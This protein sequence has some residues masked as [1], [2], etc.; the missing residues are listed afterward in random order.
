MYPI[1]FHWKTITIYSYGFFIALAMLVNFFLVNR[2][3]R[4]LGFSVQEANDLLFILFVFGIVGARLFYVAQHMDDYRSDGWQALN[5]HEGG[6]VW[7]GGFTVSV[8]AGVI[9]AR[10][11]GWPILKWCDFFTPH[12]ALGHA[13]GRLGCFFNGCCYGRVSHSMLGVVFDGDLN[14]RLP[15]QLYESL[16]LF[17]LAWGLFQAAPR[18]KPSGKLFCIYLLIYALGRF[19]L[20]FLRGDQLLYAGWTVPQWTSVLLAVVAIFS[21]CLVS[22]QVKK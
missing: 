17:I 5:I 13:L 19:A 2:R 10:W 8:L 14:P 6:L 21:F 7:Y 4:T 18:V 1:L 12:L 20:E 9:Y 16:F 22:R 15:V 3:A 11:K